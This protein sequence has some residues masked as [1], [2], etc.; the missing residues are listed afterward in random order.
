M[1]AD[2]LPTGVVDARPAGAVRGSSMRADALPTWV[3]DAHSDRRTRS[4]DWQL[5]AARRRR[6][7][8]HGR[9][10]PLDAPR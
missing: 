5:F 7:G 6:A 3:G 10:T 9:A 4:S 1:R 2:V 8:S